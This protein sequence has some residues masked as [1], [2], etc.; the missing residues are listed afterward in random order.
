LFNANVAVLYFG[1]LSVC[2][3]IVVVGIHFVART[4]NVRAAKLI[5]AEAAVLHALMATAIVSGVVADP[6]VFA[7]DAPVTRVELALGALFVQGMYALAYYTAR[8]LRGASLQSIEQLQH[9]TRLASQREALM[10]ELRADLERALRVGRG[11]RAATPCPD[12][13]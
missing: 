2:P 10:A 12:A 1:A 3:V 11:R 4:E 8:A 5:W 6:G 13:L 9:A 7:S